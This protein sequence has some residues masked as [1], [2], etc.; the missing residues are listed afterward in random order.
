MPIFQKHFH[1]WPQLNIFFRSPRLSP[2]TPVIVFSLIHYLS[3]CF[4]LSFRT[5]DLNLLPLFFFCFILFSSLNHIFAVCAIW[6]PSCK[7]GHDRHIFKTATT[8]Q[9]NNLLHCFFF[10]VNEF[11][12]LS[13]RKHMQTKITRQQKKNSNRKQQQVTDFV[14]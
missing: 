1:V 13:A 5:R 10:F 6:I 11:G 12:A 8:M 7:C 9:T 14:F 4:S 2:Y 3:G